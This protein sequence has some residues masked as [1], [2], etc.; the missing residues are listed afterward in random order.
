MLADYF[1]NFYESEVILRKYNKA[2]I[3]N[4]IVVK[5]IFALDYIWRLYKQLARTKPSIIIVHGYSTHLWTK[6]AATLRN[7]PLIH[8]EHNVEKYTPFRR[9]LLKIT[10]KYTQSYICV[11]HGVAEHLIKQGADAQKV[12]VI[13]NG[14]DVEKFKIQKE[15][16]ETYTIG[17]VARFVTQKDQMTLIKAVEYIIREK[18]LPIQLIFQGDGKKK[19]NC[20]EYVRKQNLE[21]VIK[22]ETGK[23]IELAPKLDVFVLATHYEGLPLVLCEAM[24]AQIPTIATNVPGVDEIIKH[25][26]DGYLVPH[27]DYI[28]LAEQIEFCYKNR[29]EEVMDKSTNNAFVKVNEEFTIMKM[30]QQYKKMVDKYAVRM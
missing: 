2:G 25:G 16:Q 29:N 5:D 4:A 20:V 10:D 26:I 28:K 6:F 7:I 9:W 23:F 11:S 8:V 3:Q 24:A 19:S 21:Q 30:C 14:I 17:M 15:R 22:F 12:T 18:N 13:Y 27:E 1:S